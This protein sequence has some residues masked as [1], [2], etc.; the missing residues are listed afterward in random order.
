MNAST[1]LAKLSYGWWTSSARSRMTEKIGRS[2]SS[3][4]AMRPAVTGGHGAVLEVGAVEP[5]SCHRQV[6]SIG[7]RW[8]VHV[9][10]RELELADQQLEHL[11]ARSSSATSRRTASLEPATAQLHLDR[12]EQVVGLLLLERQVGVAGD[13]ERR[14]LLDRPCRRTSGRSWAAMSC[15]T[16]TK[17]PVVEHGRAAGTRSGTLSRAKRRSPVSGSA[18]VS[19]ERQREVGDVR[20]RVAGID[21]ERREH[22]E[23]PLRRRTSSS[24]ALF[25][26]PSRSSHDTMSMPSLARSSGTSWSRNAAS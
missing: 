15:S 18:T 25:V 13:A 10:G 12:F 23:D 1:L 4:A 6:R 20:E 5:C 16:G 22:R 11:L 14:P 24:G 17:R 7:A 9:G 3:A 21:G 2:P 26:R 19:R 8:S